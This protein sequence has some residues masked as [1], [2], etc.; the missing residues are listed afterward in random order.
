MNELTNLVSEF[1]EAR[2][3]RKYHDPRS[4]VLAICSEVG[5]LAHLFRWRTKSA[6]KLSAETKLAV[7]DEIADI[8]IFL[9]SLCIEL[10]VDPEIVIRKKLEVNNRRFQTKRLG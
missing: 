2:N 7:E 3:W 5:E 1:N 6:R 9:L 10:D 4:L 8:F